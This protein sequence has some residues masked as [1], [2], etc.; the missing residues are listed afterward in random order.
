ML[1]LLQHIDIKISSNF[2][3]NLRKCLRNTIGWEWRHPY[4][5]IKDFKSQLPAQVKC[6]E[7]VHYFVGWPEPLHLPHHSYIDIQ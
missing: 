6:T 4:G 5:R 3:I 7:T 2:K 1:Q